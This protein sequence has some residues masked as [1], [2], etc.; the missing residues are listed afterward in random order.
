M[1]ASPVARALAAPKA[2]RY[3]L[4]Y[5]AG[6]IYHGGGEWLLTKGGQWSSSHPSRKEDDFHVWPTKDAAMTVALAGEARGGQF[7]HFVRAYSYETPNPE[8]AKGLPPWDTAEPM[9]WAAADG[10]VR[11]E[12]VSKRRERFG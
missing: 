2:K 5:V 4:G 7:P 8:T 1:N 9:E 12:V 6:I 11:A 3:L 10:E